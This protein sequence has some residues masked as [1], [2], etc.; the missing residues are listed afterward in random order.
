MLSS[1]QYPDLATRKIGGLNRISADATAG[2]Q[3]IVWPEHARWL[4]ARCK[5]DEGDSFRNP[6]G[7]LSL[8]G[9][10]TWKRQFK[11]IEGDERFDAR[12]RSVTRLAR[13]QMEAL[14]VEHMAEAAI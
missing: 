12:S 5:A 7:M 2:A 1:R 9:W 4:Y 6:W 13:K 3:W 11:W 8:R 14:E 10:E